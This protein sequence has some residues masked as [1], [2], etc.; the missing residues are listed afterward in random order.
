MRENEEL[1][2][3]RNPG[4]GARDVG[5]PV[6]FF[7]VGGEGWGSLQIFDLFEETARVILGSIYSVEQL[8]GKPC[9]VSREN[10]FTKFERL[11]PRT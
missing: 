8:D 9:V 6:L 4:C 1:A 5:R 2:I 11:L 3:I 7:D 10:G